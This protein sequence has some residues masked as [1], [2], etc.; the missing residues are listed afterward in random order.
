MN[1]TAKILRIFVLG[2]AVLSGAPTVAAPATGQDSV[3]RKPA[4][5][6]PAATLPSPD[7]QH[8]AAWT[9]HSGDHQGLPFIII[10]K[11]NA[12]A[13]AFD[14]QGKLLQATPVL[15]GM[16]IGD[17]MPPGVAELNMYHTQPAQ[18]VTPAGRYVAEEG[19]NLEKQSV[20]WIDYDAGIALHK[21]PAKR[22]KQQRHERMGSADPAEHRITYGCVNVW[23]AFYDRVVRPHF[24]S[25]GGI[26]YVLPDS[27][28][29]KSVFNS[30]DVDPRSLFS[31]RQARAP[32]APASTERF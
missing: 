1:P 15:L 30:Y 3:S 17:T 22:T 28:P 14:R 7:V 20:L 26:V 9:V 12:Q 25:K 5:S 10:D 19:V 29:L 24:K 23:P 21:I 27:T 32:A 8:I 31:A 2:A 11:R 18:R 6:R 13:V 4:A 16:G